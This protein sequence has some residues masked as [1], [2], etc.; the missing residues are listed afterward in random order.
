MNYL[1]APVLKNKNTCVVQECAGVPKLATH[2]HSVV[3]PN[4]DIGAISYL[5]HNFSIA[6]NLSFYSNLNQFS[7]FA[8]KL[9]GGLFLTHLRGEVPRE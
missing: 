2:K 9:E 5:I 4:S 1:H 3:I 6:S 7:F 8:A